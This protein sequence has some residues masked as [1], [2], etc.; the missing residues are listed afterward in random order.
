MQ[1]PATPAPPRR[2]CCTSPSCGDCAAGLS[3]LGRR[4]FLAGIALAASPALSAR[5][6]ASPAGEAS[7]Q[8]PIRSALR[9]QPVI[10][11]EIPVR[12]EST[13]WRAWGGIQ[14]EQDA[15]A[16]KDRIARELAQMKSGADYGLEILPLQVARNPEEAARISAGSHDTTLV[17][18]V[19][20][21]TKML[22]NLTPAEKRNVVFVRHRSGPL[23]YWYE[24]AHERYLRKT[25]DEWGQ[26]GM[27]VEDVVV[28]SYAEVSSR[29]RAYYGLK[30]TLGKRVVAIG[31]PSGFGAGGREAPRH[32]RELW[33]MEIQTV[34]YPDLGERL[35]KTAANDASLRRAK[36]DAARY[37]AQPGTSLE[38]SREFVEKCFLLTEVFHE[39]L[40]QYQ[41]DTLTINQCMGTI[42]QVSGT[43]ACL[44]LSLLNDAGYLAFCESDFVVIPSGILLSYISG[45]PVFLN[46]PTYPH[47]G[48]VTLAHC[49]APRKM[50]GV[51]TEPV[52]LLTHFE[53]DFGAA[54]KVEMRKG[55]KM[56]HLVPDFNCR[57][58]TGYTGEIVEVP[59]LPICRSQI[60]VT[61]PGDTV[62]LLEQMRG[63]HW[64]S[65][66]GDYL[67]EVKFA[68]RKLGLEW[69]KI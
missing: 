53:S 60:E 34:T 55:Q 9:V 41:T 37:L 31:G 68:T 4:E 7:R 8:M 5:A 43:T 38:T 65:C 66:Y 29:L 42:M 27:G 63:F 24:G 19:S 56:T 30:N 47:D 13:S 51:N 15:A 39:L 18:A 25:V 10:F 40:D 2:S 21:S 22:E 35:K 3:G 14:T 12:R 45:K 23:Y 11:Y 36:A 26:P 28:D 50:D 16:E 64:M 69:S 48:L 17:Y 62:E 49:T 54:P 44:P 52:R 67:R 1:N 59:F 57:R 61:T 33:K 46:D 20:G 6:V 32:A 58:W